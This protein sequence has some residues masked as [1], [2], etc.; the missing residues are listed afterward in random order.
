MNNDLQRDKPGPGFV[1]LPEWLGEWWFE[2]LTFEV[3]TQRGWEKPSKGANEAFDLFCYAR[4]GAIK[5]G[6]EQLDWAR[7]KPFARGWDEN[8]H[9]HQVAE[10]SVVKPRPVETANQPI[11]KTATRRVRMQVSR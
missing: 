11:K 3:R 10:V 2:E 9:V 8:P 7:P 5:L 6:I 1:H 4:A